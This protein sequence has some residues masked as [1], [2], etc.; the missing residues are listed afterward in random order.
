MIALRCNPLPG[1]GLSDGIAESLRAHCE[2]ARLRVSTRV[3]GHSSWGEV[4]QKPFYLGETPMKVEEATRIAD[5][6]IEKLATALAAGQS[7]ALKQYFSTISRMYKYSFRNLLLIFSQKPD[8]TFVAGFNSWKKQQRWVKKGEKG[9]VIIA[10]MPVKVEQAK[11]ED[12]EVVTRFRAGYVFDVSQTEGEPFAEFGSVTGEPGEHLKNLKTLIESRVIAL[13]Y[14]ADLGGAD[15]M[16]KGGAIVIRSNQSQA[17]EFSVLVHEFAHELLH[18]GEVEKQSKTVRETEAEAVAYVV[19][20]GVGLS[21]NSASSN[22]IQL[23]RGD[24]D[25]L[26]MSLA[27]IQKTATT[28]LSGLFP[29]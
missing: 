17:Q 22:Y 20:E 4:T 25:T 21:A 19:A 28:I 15:G 5:K 6:Q 7:E 1:R 18:H 14:E 8:A 2:E 9:I 13:S 16:S 10:P 3:F 24:K 23:Y 12:P 26:E 27:A 11:S 29:D